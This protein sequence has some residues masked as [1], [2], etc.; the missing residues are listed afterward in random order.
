MMSRFCVGRCWSSD[1]WYG[2]KI[3]SSYIVYKFDLILLGCF[4]GSLNQ[5]TQPSVEGC[6]KQPFCGHVVQRTRGQVDT[7]ACRSQAPHEINTK[8]T[9]SLDVSTPVSFVAPFLKGHPAVNC[10]EVTWDMRHVLSRKRFVWG[11]EGSLVAEYFVCFA[12]RTP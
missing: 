4:E 5:L 8:H 6:T 7:A 1:C 10:S 9:S 11:T 2:S 3:S 12:S